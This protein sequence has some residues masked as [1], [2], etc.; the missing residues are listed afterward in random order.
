MQQTV[1]LGTFHL[2]LGEAGLW[3]EC[4]DETVVTGIS[5][6]TRVDIVETKQLL[7][8]WNDSS[9][10]LEYVVKWIIVL[11]SNDIFILAAVFMRQQNVL[12]S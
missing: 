2:V 4:H 11:R 3:I 12:F 7:W 8:L 1:Q 9:Q 10:V 5:L 6:A